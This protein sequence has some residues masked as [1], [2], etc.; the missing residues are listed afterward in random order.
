MD[1]I[2]SF[3][4]LASGIQWRDLID[5]I[6]ALDTQRKLD[7]IARQIN[8]QEKRREAWTT[9]QGLLD[10]V[11]SA[12]ASLRDGSAF[13]K[14]SVTAGT[15]SVSDRKVFSATAS[16]A[17]A[18]GSYEVQVMKLAKN[19]KLAGSA[20]SDVAAALNLAG[21]FHVNGVAVTVEAT[22][23]LSD[24]RDRINDANTGSSPSGVT[25]TILSTSSTSHQLILT[26]DGTG[27]SGIELIESEGATK[28]L[29][30]LGI[31]T[32]GA[33]VANKSADGTAWESQR[34]TSQDTAVAQMLGLTSPPATANIVVDGVAVG[35]DLQN[36]TL[37]EVLDNIQSALQAASKA[38]SVIDGVRIVSE[39]VGGRTTYRLS[40]TTAV[41][42]ETDAGTGAPLAESQRAL[43]LLGFQHGPRAAE[44]QAG[45]DAEV[46]VDGFTIRR[47][48]NTISDALEGITLTLTSEAPTESATLTVGRDLD[49]AVE[50]VQG[51]A[52][53]YNAVVEFMDEQGTP[54]SVLYANGTL[55]SMMSSLKDVLLEEVVGIDPA[56]NPYHRTAIAG[57]ALSRD[58]FL[59]IDKETL[60]GAL[61]TNLNDIRALFGT[62]G[63]ATDPDVTFINGS[64]DTP[65]GTFSVRVTQVATVASASSSGFGGTYLDDGSNA[66]TLTISDA[67]TGGEGSITLADGDTTADIVRKLNDLFDAQGMTLTAR[68]SGGQ[69]VVEGSKYGSSASFTVSYSRGG[70]AATPQAGLIAAGTYAGLDVAGLINGEAA[71]GSGQVL[72]AD[73]G[74]TADGLAVMYQGT[75]PAPLDVGTVTYLHGVA[76]MAERVVDAFTRADTGTIS[77]QLDSID[78]SIESLERREEDVALR[79][80]LRR[81]SLI[82]QF[83]AMETALS[84]I[85]AQGNWLAS[86]I[87]ALQS[88]RAD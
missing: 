14:F 2:G 39:E 46:L 87:Q 86:Q 59:E 85:Q 28:V 73:D 12:A 26:A 27:T 6:V 45:T 29:Q 1:P 53:A 44:I 60:E 31:H 80:D 49:G 15:T 47:R 67:Y 74:T 9:F 68:E 41:T 48:T 51:F 82:K 42:V 62:A 7:P 18:P 24:I 38:Q 54:G 37:T 88:S 32:A 84:R 70:V 25:A 10:G 33:T 34:F 40:S 76:G 77:L 83:T 61:Q 36:D 66:N 81:E 69:L 58:G 21:T 75:G 19:E 16:S 56:V 13:G 35:V 3:S 5:Q 30:G 65:A 71:T 11:K 57:V 52:D 55:R 23:S 43:E 50:E 79:I 72:T 20:V 64:S 4:G 17:A 22:D 78:S 8:L 63:S